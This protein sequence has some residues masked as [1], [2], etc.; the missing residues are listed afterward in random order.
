MSFKVLCN[1][2]IFVPEKYFPQCHASTLVKLN[3]GDILAAWFGGPYEDHVDVAIWFSRRK[4]ECWTEPVKV[5]DEEGDPCWNPVLFQDACGKIHLFYKVGINPRNWYTMLITSDDSGYSWSV[6]QELI[7]GDIGGRGP[8]KNKA[9]ILSDGTWL[10]PASIET[11]TSWDAFADISRDNGKTWVKSGMVPL[12]HEKLQ[13]KGIIQPTLWESEPG[14]VHMLLRS[15]EGFIFR[16][17][18]TDFGNT[19][20]DARITDTPNNNSGI[21]VAQLEDGKLVL[22]YN[23]IKGNWGARTPVVCSISADNGRTWRESFILDHNENPVDKIDGE[24]SYPAIISEGNRVYIAY[25]WKRKT[26][27][28]WE[29]EI[30]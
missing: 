8:V 5:A 25:T 23:P 29:L 11:D 26:V 10:A 24:F 15:S 20:S 27:A 9:I 1:E 13:G 21:D 6:P 14:M 7:P 28:F 17:D 2:H 22:V 4:D 18:S 19:W 16:S 30:G 3:N 12:D